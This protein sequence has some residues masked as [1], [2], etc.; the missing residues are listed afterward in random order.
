M[1]PLIFIIGLASA[2][3]EKSVKP[4]PV[5]THAPKLDGDLRDLTPATD[6]AMPESARSASAQLKV[7]ATFRQ[8]TL[9]VGVAVTD[10]TALEGDQLELTLYFPNSGTTSRGFVY[11]FGREGARPVSPDEAGPPAFAAKLVRA[12]RALH[13]NGWALEAAFPARALPRFQGAKPLVISICAEYRKAEPALGPRTLLSSCPT[14]EMASGPARL[15]DEFRKSLKLVPPATVEGVEARET[16]WVGFSSAHAPTWVSADEALTPQLLATLV[17]GDQAVDPASVA[18]PVPSALT[19][20]DHRPLFSV[21]T[22]QNPF[23]QDRCDSKRELRLALYLVRK[24]IAFRV[25][26]WPVAT[27]ELGRA[28]RFELSDEGTLIIGYTNGATQHFIWSDDH[29]ERSELG[30]A[31]PTHFHHRSTM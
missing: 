11:R 1:A 24:K 27:C 19:L 10:A 25:L 13:A 16:G 4:L 5:L 17:E 21:L 30:F 20:G 29:F 7:K 9:F 22:G 31:R 15:P 23:G 12:A 26:D 6:F 8:D 28:M 18:L 2:P 3:V 14:G